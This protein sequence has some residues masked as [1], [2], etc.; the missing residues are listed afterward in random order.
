MS[1][2]LSLVATPIGNHEDITYRALQVL[3]DADLVVCEER[4]EGERLLRHFG[5]DKPVETLNEHNEAASAGVIVRA[6]KAGKNVA[7]VS[8]WRSRAASPS[9]LFPGPRH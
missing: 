7:L 1:G 9:S 4:R 3:R 8:E 2:T 5:I 6:L